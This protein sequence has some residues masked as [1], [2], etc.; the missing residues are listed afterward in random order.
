MNKSL[1]I[2]AFHGLKHKDALKCA[3]SY[4]RD[5]QSTMPP[6]LPEELISFIFSHLCVTADI[7]EREDD[8]VR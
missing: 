7:D 3:E 8:L 6:Y 5:V 1:V 2:E 4:R